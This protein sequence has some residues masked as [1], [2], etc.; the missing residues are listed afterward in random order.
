MLILIQINSITLSPGKYIKTSDINN[1]ISI[2]N[3]N[4]TINGNRPKENVIIDIRTIG[5]IFSITGNSNV[6]FI[7][8]TFI[9]GNINGNGG[10]IR[11]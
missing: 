8:I 9:N 2:N 3:I 1:V 5:M 11:I 4:L 10:A 6:T 7:N